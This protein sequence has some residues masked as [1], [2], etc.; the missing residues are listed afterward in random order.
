LPSFATLRRKL[1]ELALQVGRDEGRVLDFS[2][3]SIHEVE[4]ILAS[5][6]RYYRRTRKDDGLLGL[7]LEF[8]AYI[9]ETVDRNYPPTG[10]WRRNHPD[11]GPDT[12]PY[13]WRGTTLFPVA[14]CHKR[15]LDGPGDNVVTKFESL[16]IN[17]AQDSTGA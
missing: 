12:F 14:W 2:P 13:D 6:H 7:A 9:V 16:V 1:I 17:R 10:R 5:V 11:L 15:L 4:A 3:E 8:G